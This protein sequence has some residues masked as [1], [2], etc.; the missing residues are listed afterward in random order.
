MLRRDLIS[1]AGLLASGAL[2]AVALG[3]LMTG[4][5]TSV[6]SS[7]ASDLSLYLTL[8]ALLLTGAKLGMDGYLLSRAGTVDLSGSDGMTRFFRCWATPAAIVGGLAAGWNF[9]W[10]VSLPTA[11]SLLLDVRSILIAAKLSGRGDTTPQSIGT[12]LNF[13]LFF[14]FFYAASLITAPTIALAACVFAA[15]SVARF[16]YMRG[17]AELPNGPNQVG[18]AV[19]GALGAQQVLNYF[20]Y[21]AD[22]ILIG[23]DPMNLLVD[24]SSEKLLTDYLL[25]AKVYEVVCTVTFLACMVALPKVSKGLTVV[26]ASEASP[27]EVTPGRRIEGKR[28]DRSIQVLSLSLVCLCISVLIYGWASPERGLYLPFLAAAGLSLLVN[29]QTLLSLR[30]SSLRALI[31]ALVAALAAG[32]VFVGFRSHPIP[33][34]QLA[35]LVPI[36]MLV[37]IVMLYRS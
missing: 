32:A 31:V 14:L 23:L 35:Y 5:V 24:P 8:Y 10:E 28:A 1:L 12:L 29:F 13:P 17:N 18:L 30:R 36:Q 15:S 21:R 25:H 27:S 33:L 26:G 4:R 22:Q 34:D 19:L 9:G 16:I 11:F 20:L 37:F 2:S 6:P 3:V 7:L